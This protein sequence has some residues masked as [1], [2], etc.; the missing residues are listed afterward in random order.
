MQ[1]TQH[2]LDQMYMRR[3]LQLAANGRGSCTPNP[4]VGA[5]VVWNGQIIGEG[6][7][8][9]A[10]GPHAEPIAIRSVQ[11]QERLSAST[12][13][14]NLEPCSHHGKTPPCVDLILEKKIPRVVVGS[15]DVFPLVAGRGVNRLIAAGVDVRVG[16]EWDACLELNRRFF[17]Y[18]AHK[19][20]YVILKWAQ[21]SDGFLDHVRA[22]GDAQLPLMISSPFMRVLTHRDRAEEDA[23]LVGTRTAILDNPKLNVRD[24]SGKNPI[25]VVLDRK[26]ILSTDLHLF[27]GSCPTLVFT[28]KACDPIPG[29]SFVLL[30]P[31]QETLPQ[32]LKTLYE[33][34]CLSVLVEGGARMHESFL[35]SGLW[36]E[37]HVEVG[38]S[39]IGRGV[40]APDLHGLNA[41]LVKEE[42][43]GAGDR[44]RKR[45]IY[46]APHSVIRL[47]DA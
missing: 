18:H 11:Q 41:H 34:K 15:L 39:E 5:V 20:P 21:T 6:W 45:K 44:L 31:N 23:I 38:P 40:A 32:V 43:F 8:Q 16:V 37:I 17:T 7:H 22:H 14:V 25:R 30:D 1:Q 27:D 9:K 13:Y 35:Q 3:C 10:G 4:M 19:R 2:E 46:R 12:L 42:Q 33:R 28:E 47:T 36:D 29:V 24:W 26:R